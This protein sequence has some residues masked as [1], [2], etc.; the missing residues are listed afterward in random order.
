MERI[1]LQ[2]YQEGVPREVNLAEFRSVNEILEK[3][4][5]RFRHQPAFTNMGAGITYGEL[6][7]LSQQFGAYLQKHLKLE[8]G[9]RV[10]L[11]MPNL[12]QYPV[13]LFGVL[14]AGLIVVNVNPLYTPGE[15]R[16]QLRDSGAEVILVLENFASTLQEV[17]PDTSVRSVIV[18][19]IGDMLPTVKSWLVN[20]VVRRVKKMIPHWRIEGTHRFRQALRI[21][22]KCK[23]ERMSVTPED[24]AFLQ[25]TGST[26][27]A[28]RGAM[29]THGNIIANVQQTTAWMANALQEGVETIVT[30]L[31]LYHIF[32]LTVNC[33][34]FVKQGANN[35]LITN[36]RDI[37]G[38]VSELKKIKFSVITGVNTLYNVLLNVPQMR[39][40]DTSSLKFAVGGGMA[41]QRAV[42]EKWQEYMGVPIIEGYGLTETSPV[43][44]I[45]P[46]NAT[47]FSG[48]IGLPVPS[49]EV[50]IRDDEGAELGIAQVGEICVRGPQVMKGYWNMPEETERAFTADGFLRTGDMGRID[51]SG[52]VYLT[53]RKKDVIIVSGFNVY[54]NEVENVVAMHSGVL[55][56]AAVGV[57]DEHSGEAVKIIVVRKDPNLS[58]EELIEH[59]RKHL[60]RY[61][62]PH[63]VEF[64]TEPLPK[65]SVGKVL[66]RSLRDGRPGGSAAKVA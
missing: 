17:L 58:P 61:K 49:T 46:L 20:F 26:T 22:A 21:G 29:L 56:C 59:C 66:R 51:E 16:H 1:W 6:D 32:S 39:E 35:V 36:P 53:D 2:R 38:F 15:L 41:V 25:Y 27:G 3:S 40:V 28:A 50:S 33:L 52:F 45:N 12:L 9:T 57:P 55:E 63:Q 24:V 47:E 42:A 18:T 31:P 30:P 23:L 4:C 19:G 62:V 44:C 48:S 11:M 8:K 60:T 54:P 13:A 14:R 34:T 43:V 64:R 65:T 7:R 37:P 5:S 10:A